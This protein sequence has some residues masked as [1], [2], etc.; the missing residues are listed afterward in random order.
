MFDGEPLWL[1]KF[2][3]LHPSKIFK[4]TSKVKT[5]MQSKVF[6]FVKNIVALSP[7]RLAF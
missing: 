5:Q 7:E 3:N 6:D 2:C 1:K 4:E